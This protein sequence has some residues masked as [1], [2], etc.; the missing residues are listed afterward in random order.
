MI[1]ASVARY[2]QINECRVMT[3]TDGT[4]ALALFKADHF[5][6]GI[7]DIDLPGLNGLSLLD[8]MQSLRPD[9]R[10]ILTSGSTELERQHFARQEADATVTFI[11]K[12]FDLDALIHLIRGVPA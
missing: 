8:Q 2:L 9:C 7:L 3:C 6:V 12:P 1:V 5:D 11:A 10:F 4:Q